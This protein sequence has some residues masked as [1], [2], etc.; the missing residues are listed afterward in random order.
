MAA[1]LKLNAQ[2]FVLDGEIILLI[3]GKL[4][5][6]NLLQR[7]HPAASRVA[8]LSQ[9]H[10]VQ[11]VLFDLLVNDRGLSLLDRPFA[12][13]RAA[14]E[15]FLAKYAK[16]SAAFILSPTTTEIPTARAG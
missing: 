8:K 4:S 10:P 3:D 5:F 1:L 9:Q 14:L 16:G 11:F 13:R 7:I 12:K 2:K 15:S 6:D